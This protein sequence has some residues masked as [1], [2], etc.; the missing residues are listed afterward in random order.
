VSAIPS[1]LQQ[2][3]GRALIDVDF[4]TRLMADVRGTL[5]AEGMSFDEATL[6]AIEAATRDPEKVRSFSDS[7]SSQFLSRG[8]YVG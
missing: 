1:S 3:V 7:F 2:L 5:S 6:V 4:R 8:E